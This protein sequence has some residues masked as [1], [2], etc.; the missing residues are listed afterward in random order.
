MLKL[1]YSP[2]MSPEKIWKSCYFDD[3]VF[4]LP[5]SCENL[6]FDQ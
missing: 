1:V 5:A 6:Y 4:L 3:V 2:L